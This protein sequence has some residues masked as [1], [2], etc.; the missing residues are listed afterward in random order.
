M[1]PNYSFHVTP[2]SLVLLIST[3]QFL[4]ATTFKARMSFNSD[5]E[6]KPTSFIEI[7]L[8]LLMGF[9]YLVS[10]FCLYFCPIKLGYFY[11]YFYS[12]IVF[13]LMAPSFQVF[14]LLVS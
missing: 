11:L 1:V 12:F 5:E 4:L 6:F 8:F 3:I 13:Y 10:T 14:K 2:I 9:L 7:G